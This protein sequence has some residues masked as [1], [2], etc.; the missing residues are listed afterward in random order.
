MKRVLVIGIGA[1]DPDHVTMQAVNALNQVDVFFALDKG[2][3]KEKL[4]RLRREICQRF[5]TGTGYRFVTADIPERRRGDPDY[6]AAV[7]ILNEEKAL[8]FERLI[9]TELGEEECGAF[10]VWGDPG[11]YDSTIRIL[12]SL[13]ARGPPAFEFEVIPGISSVQALAREAQGDAEPDRAGVPGDDGAAG[14]RRACRT[15]STTSS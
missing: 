5:I 3:E 6:Q 15:T 10:L 2:V 4:A 12:Q 9:G 7:S 11:L 13:L 8:L 14:S 1:G